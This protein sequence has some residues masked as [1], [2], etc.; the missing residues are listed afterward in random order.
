[1]TGKRIAWNYD[2]KFAEEFLP[3]MLTAEYCDENMQQIKLP[4]TNKI[5]PFHYF[6][7]KD[8]QMVS[9]YR[10]TFEPDSEWSGNNIIVHFEAVAHHAEIFLNGNM[11]AKH[12]GGYTAFQVDITETL[13]YG[14][15]NV[16]CVMADSRENLNIP[17]FGN[18]VDYMTYGGIYREV[19]LEIRPQTYII[20]L[21]S[22]T[23]DTKEDEKRLYCSMEIKGSGKVQIRQLL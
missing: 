3:D 10:K 6:D 20:D 18:V 4:H 2:W 23:G 12:D 9:A 13:E 15:K 8:Y 11:I 17:P 19:F 16:L 22:T 14:K 7:E 5:L 21:F 1:M